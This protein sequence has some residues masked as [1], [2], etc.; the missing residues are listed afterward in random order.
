MEG[1]RVSKGL[2]REGCER[3]SRYLVRGQV[4]VDE[5]VLAFQAVDGELLWEGGARTSSGWEAAA[6]SF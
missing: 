6:F 2:R 5:R 4:P 3:R 1:R